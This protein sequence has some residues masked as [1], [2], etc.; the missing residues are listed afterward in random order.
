M[1][2]LFVSVLVQPYLILQYTEK[3]HPYILQTFSGKPS[4]QRGL[5][6]DLA[7]FLQFSLIHYKSSSGAASMFTKLKS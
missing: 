1:T 2:F 6:T 5:S 3:K 7:V 4:L